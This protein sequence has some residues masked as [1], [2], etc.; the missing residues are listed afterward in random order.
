[1]GNT[2]KKGP[3][4]RQKKK[5]WPALSP[6]F[7]DCEVV[8]LTGDITE[9]LRKSKYHNLFHRAFVGALAA[10]PFLEEVTADDD[11]F[12]GA[13]KIRKPPRVEAPDAFGNKSMK[14]SLGAAMKDGAVVT[15]E[16]L[17]YQAH[18]EGSARLAFRH[19]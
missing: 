6:G 5:D 1:M 18:F 9:T 2:K 19:K 10:V 3:K 12:K 7:A 11:T 15:F 4:T 14:S 16:T 17:K 8:L 13:R